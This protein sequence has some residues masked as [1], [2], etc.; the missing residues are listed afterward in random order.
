[1]TDILF[2][3][4]CLF[5]DESHLKYFKKYSH[6]SCFIECRSNFTMELCKCISMSGIRKYR[7]LKIEKRQSVFM[8]L[9]SYQKV[10]KTTKYATQMMRIALPRFAK[11]WFR[12]QARVSSLAIACQSA[13]AL[14][15]PTPST[16]IVLCPQTSASSKMS[17]PLRFI[18]LTMSSLPTNGS[19]VMAQWVS[20]QI[21][22]DYLD[23]SWES[24]C[25]HLWKLFTFLR[26]DSST[27][28]GTPR[29][30]NN[31]SIVLFKTV[32]NI[33]SC[34]WKLQ[35]SISKH[36]FLN[37]YNLLTFRQQTNWFSAFCKYNFLPAT[38]PEPSR[39]NEILF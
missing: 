16:K 18:I 28:C 30:Y 39:I 21:S 2:R 29:V 4:N 1:M 34:H 5:S 13:T 27:I 9:F 11:L 24:R 10:A 12:A 31:K 25:C 19:K 3:R 36:L 35:E 23:S 37:S 6:R 20:C 15:I 22:V 17:A 14:S 8:M 26:C 33:L 7:V 32:N 38:D